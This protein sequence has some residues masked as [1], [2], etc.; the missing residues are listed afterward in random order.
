MKK[1]FPWL[2]F[3]FLMFLPESVVAVVPTDAPVLLSEKLEGKKVEISRLDRKTI[4]RQLG[5]KLNL[6]ERV[7]LWIVKKDIKKKKQVIG[8]KE[9]SRATHPLAVFAVGVAL[10]S[11]LVITGILA[12]IFGIIALH[13]IK[14]YPEKW[15]GKGWATAAILLAL[16]GIPAGFLIA[17]AL[18]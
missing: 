2:I 4:E 11:P 12:I 7:F 5:R 8:K 1:T 10:F 6:Q 18:A 17:S 16:I 15:K 14:T 13:E 9:D 3:I